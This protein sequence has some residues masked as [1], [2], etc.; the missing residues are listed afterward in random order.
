MKLNYIRGW[1]SSSRDLGS[2]EY[3]LLPLIPGT[4]SA[5]IPVKAVSMDGI[6]LFNILLDRAQKKKLF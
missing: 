6:E 1:G 2:V 4:H 5:V 3:F